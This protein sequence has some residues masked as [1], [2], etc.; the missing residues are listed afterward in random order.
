MASKKTL[1]KKLEELGVKPDEKMTNKE[2]EA[3]IQKVSKEPMEKPEEKPAKKAYKFSP[4]YNR[5]MEKLSSNE[6][7]VYSEDV[8]R[9]MPAFRKFVENISDQELADL[10]K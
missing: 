8:V 1:L 9:A 7:R 3:E 4:L 6:E 10:V 5:F 2:L